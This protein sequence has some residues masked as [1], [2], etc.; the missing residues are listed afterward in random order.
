MSA[1]SCQTWYLYLVCMISRCI[2][3]PMS[4]I[5]RTPRATT[6]LSLVVVEVSG[7]SDDRI[8]D[9]SACHLALCNGPHLLQ[10]HAADLL[11][12]VQFLKA[13]LHYCRQAAYHN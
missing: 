12:A 5:R 6:H 10:H 7:H 2:G 11:R 1:A 13:A 3:R 4:R 8:G 9:S